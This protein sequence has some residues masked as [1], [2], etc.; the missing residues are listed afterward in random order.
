MRLAIPR[1]KYKGDPKI[2]ALCQ[3][4]L[5]RVKGLP[6][7]EVAGMANRLPLSGPGGVSAIEF[8]RKGE[9]NGI[10][11][12]TDDNTITPDYLRAM[13]IPLLRGRFFSEADNAG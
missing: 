6:Q 4:I 8:E 13:E 1:N 3:N 5:E 7:V 11:T 9:P 10:L 2:I 12:T